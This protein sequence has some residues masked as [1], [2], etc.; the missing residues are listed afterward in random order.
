MKKGAD[1]FREKLDAKFAFDSLPISGREQ[2][3]QRVSPLFQTRSE[4]QSAR[5]YHPFMFRGN[6]Q[7]GEAV[8]G[9][10]HIISML[11]F[12]AAFASTPSL[13][14]QAGE[15]SLVRTLTGRNESI[16]LRAIARIRGD[17]ASRREALDDLIAAARRNAGETAS[18]D[19]VRPSTVQ[20]IQLIGTI[21]SPDSESLLIDLLDAPHV[22]IA[23]LSSDVLGKYK[24]YGAIEFLKK[25]VDR[26]EY[27]TKYGF[28]FNLVRSL[29]QMEHPDAV[30]FLSELRG[31]LDGQLRYQLELLLSD[32]TVKHF[33]GDEQRYQNWKSIQD[34]DQAEQPTDRDIVF[35]PAAFE[36]ES[37]NRIKLERPHQYYGIDIHAKRML[38]I[39]DHSGSMRHY[40]GGYSR[41]QRA[42][43]ELIRAITELPEDSKFG[44]IFYHTTV[45]QWRNE[46]LEASEENKREAIQFVRRLGLGNKT[47]TYAA[48]RRSL[49]FD[50]DLEAVFVLTDGRPTAGE[51]VA[52]TA[53]VND[54]LHRNRFRHLNFN[55]IG[56]AVEG[57][58]EAFLRRLAE[59]TN[60]EYRQAL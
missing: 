7:D 20:L 40:W 21:D 4:R 2:N 24:F 37:L 48:L 9:C 43:N 58:T 46:L 12:L 35:R 17:A 5:I 57:P 50:D 45:K 44:I 8:A 30:E 41:L 42:K 53:I 3:F 33:H 25:Q 56:I 39:I 29:A 51:I 22:G 16:R 60:G 34:S 19:L 27:A 28:R 18:G 59:E 55:T 23:M 14:D 10:R 26:P 11:F 54:V 1:P 13:A 47:N 49:E 31:T 6:A 32:V 15:S 38:F 52:P 36:P